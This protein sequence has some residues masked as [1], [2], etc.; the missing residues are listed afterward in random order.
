MELRLLL[1]Q[2]EL[3]LQDSGGVEANA[4]DQAWKAMGADFGSRVA[5]ARASGDRPALLALLES[6]MT[7][8]SLRDAES[9]EVRANLAIYMMARAS[10]PSAA[11]ETRRL[12]ELKGGAPPAPYV[13][14]P[15]GPPPLLLPPPPACQ[16][17]L[18]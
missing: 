15:G 16:P 18:G 1:I 9:M 12:Y 10:E 11:A 7:R 5:A 14:K 6:F 3:R 4:L 17:F 8:I 13:P 2:S